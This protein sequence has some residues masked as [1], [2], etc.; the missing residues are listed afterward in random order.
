M[1]AQII[2][3]AS[4]LLLVLTI[5][6]QVYKQWKEGACEGVSIWLFV[7]QTAASAGFTI[8]SL[9]VGDW[10]FVVTNAVML[11]NGVL[12]YAILMRNRRNQRRRAA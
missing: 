1:S 10:V 11:V 2:G 7:G 8:Y 12:G 5:G 4:S 3:W 9:L 6:K